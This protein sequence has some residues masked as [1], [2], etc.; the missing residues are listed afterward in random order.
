MG[1]L[2][3][4]TGMRG[5]VGLWNFI[6]VSRAAPGSL[7]LLAEASQCRAGASLPAVLSMCLSQLLRAEPS[8]FPSP[9]KG[10]WMR[11]GALARCRATGRL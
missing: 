11:S 9:G 8:P 3:A 7:G 2:P 5:T 6:P 4:G 10:R 1:W